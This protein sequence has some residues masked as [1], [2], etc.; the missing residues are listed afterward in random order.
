MKKGILILILFFLLPLSSA[1][2]F[3]NNTGGDNQFSLGTGIFAS[4]IVANSYIKGIVGVSQIPIVT[5][6]DNDGISEIIVLSGS[7]IKIYEDKM[8]NPIA[9]Y[10]LPVG[11]QSNLITFDVDAD[12]K[13]E[14][15][16]ASEDN[17]S[18]NILSFNN[19]ILTLKN[20]INF[21]IYVN[22]YEDAEFIIGCRN[23]ND[24]LVSYTDSSWVNRN[25][26]I[27]GI[28]F[29]STNLISASA[30][31]LTLGGANTNCMP[32]IRNMEI[33]DY[34]GDNDKEFIFSVGVTGDSGGLY[35]LFVGSNKTNIIVENVFHKDIYTAT[36]IPCKY[37]NAQLRNL[38]TSPIVADFDTGGALETI[39]AAMINSNEYKI[40]SIKSNM[41]YDSFPIENADGEILSN[42]IK[43]NAFSVVKGNNKENDF[44]VL[45]YQASEQLLDLNCASYE[46][47]F[48]LHHDIEYFYNYSGFNLTNTYMF[49]NTAIHSVEEKDSRYFDSDNNMKEIL[50][51]YGIFQL[52]DEDYWGFPV[53]SCKSTFGF[54]KCRMNKIYQ[55]SE[56]NSAVISVDY[57]KNNKEDLILATQI[58]IEYIDDIF[59]NTAPHITYYKI[60]PCITTTWKV[61]TSVQVTIEANDNENDNLNYELCLYCNSENEI[62]ITTQ[63]VSSNIRATLTT[64]A[65]ITTGTGKL[66]IKATDIYGNYN[67]TDFLF[68]VADDGAVL[69]DCYTEKSITEDEVLTMNITNAFGVNVENNKIKKSLL[70]FAEYF[71]VGA[72]VIYFVFMLIGG[73]ALI[74]Y[75]HKYFP[76]MT[77]SNI[78]L[79][80]GISE[81]MLLM[82]GIMIGMVTIG[83]LISII[84][85]C[86]VIIGIYLGRKLG[87]SD[88]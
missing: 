28:S 14:I 60:N 80:T 87:H 47:S 27:Y 30:N 63:N 78:L 65:N 43:T 75:F 15:I 51:S 44:C 46:S 71:G 69:N 79:I 41:G 4:Q 58:N 21:G 73:I 56:D 52:T 6:L 32:K 62:K 81:F 39:I 84:I 22:P 17:A 12:L 77:I 35:V 83:I 2:I 64:K 50:T 55:L 23:S 86:T 74:F 53:G 70:P 88:S 82:I 31:I 7:T 18:I 24:C 26:H 37:P 49:Y 38:F 57:E 5:D 8:L 42:P 85:I 25:V 34:D 68:S 54:N 11:Y 29:N 33:E 9:S 66:R 20:S 10:D 59:T 72:V 19:S 13:R 48:H 36:Q 3:Y 45:G 61:N 1:S 16:I 76:E 40:Y 67:Y